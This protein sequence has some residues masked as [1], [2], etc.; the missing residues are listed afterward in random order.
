MCLCM[1]E[2]IVSQTGIK[3]TPNT[4]SLFY[5][6]G[7]QLGITY[8]DRQY[9]VCWNCCQNSG[10]MLC[11]YVKMNQK[12]TFQQ[13]FMFRF[14]GIVHFQIENKN[15]KITTTFFRNISRLA[16]QICELMS[17]NYTM[18]PCYYYKQPG[19]SSSVHQPANLL[20]VMGVR[21][22]LLLAQCKAGDISKKCGSYFKVLFSKNEQYQKGPGISHKYICYHFRKILLKGHRFPKRG[23][24]GQVQHFVRLLF[25]F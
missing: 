6:K 2:R 22:Q 3:R 8:I 24:I 15:L 19:C 14:F 12:T 20:K 10:R 4:L 16:M 11:M 23:Y 21:C 7:K 1:S 9:S 18:F 25:Y 5:E 13:Y 17:P